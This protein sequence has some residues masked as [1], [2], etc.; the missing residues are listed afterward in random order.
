[1]NMEIGSFIGLDLRDSGE[2]YNQEDNIARLNS[3]RAGIYHACKL[4]GCH[5]VYIPYY[6]C[7]T[8][9]EF[10]NKKGIETIHYFIN[11]DFEPILIKQ[12]RTQ[13]VLLVNYF[14]ILSTEKINILAGRYD[15]VIIDNSAAFY[16]SPVESCFAVYSPRKFFG[17]P[18]GCYVL[19]RDAGRYVDEYRQDR[20]SV[21]ASFLMKTLESGTSDSYSDR[22]KNEERIDQSDILQMSSLTRKLL[23]SIDYSAVK[24]VRKEN[25]HE[26]TDKCHSPAR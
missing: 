4:Y 14:G 17:V 25:F 20:S 8:V 10:L 9:K 7:P 3:A 16:S 13:A 2:Y 21:T 5:S 26:T 19:G 15:R 12:E 11:N 18:D 22:M 23:N 24:K 6:L 1:M